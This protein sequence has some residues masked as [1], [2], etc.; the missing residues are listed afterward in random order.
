[1][2]DKPITLPSDKAVAYLVKIYQRLDLALQKEITE[3]IREGIEINDINRIRA[4]QARVAVLLSK[5]QKAALPIVTVLQ[6]KGYEAGLDFS[7]KELRKLRR[8]VEVNALLGPRDNAAVRVLAENAV[9]QFDTINQLVGRRVNDAIRAVALDEVA[10]SSAAGEGRRELASRLQSALTRAGLVNSSGEFSF[11]TINGRNYQLDKYVELVARTT[12]REAAT[13]GMKN[14][15]LDNGLD[16]V[17]VDGAEVSC[18]ICGPYL[19]NT[20][21]L[22]GETEGYEISPTLPLHPNCRCVLTPAPII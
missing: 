10:F 16:L 1:M 15:L 7:L 12:T 11:I 8:A 22:T 5:A 6:A 14:R 3:A 21:S 9:S 20:Y 17:I 2:A 19:G 4:R 18:D 13:Q